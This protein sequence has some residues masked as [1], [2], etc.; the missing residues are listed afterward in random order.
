MN[1]K[2]YIKTTAAECAVLSKN[3]NHCETEEELRARGE[4]IYDYAFLVI[5]ERRR[6]RR[7]LIRALKGLMR[8]MW[9]YIKASMWELKGMFK[10][11]CFEVKLK[12]IRHRYSQK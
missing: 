1:L 4:C 7:K 12:W 10:V 9:N 2:K 3:R 5:M 11:L 8:R 6:E